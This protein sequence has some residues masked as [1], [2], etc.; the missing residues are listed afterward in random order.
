MKN[1]NVVALV[2]LRGGSKSI[3][4]KNIKLLNGKPL[5]YYVLKAATSAA[6]IDAVYVST[7]SDRIAAIVDSL[8]MDINLIKR[9]AE[10]ATDESST[11][12]VMLHFA[13]SV[14]FETLI[15][16][17]ATSPLTTNEHLN[18]A[19]NMLV[20]EGYD[21]LLTGV[22]TLRFYWGLDGK[23]LNYNPAA[24]PRRQDF[25][26]V[27]VENGAFYITKRSILCQQKCRLGGEIGIYEMPETSEVELDEPSDWSRVST[28]LG[29]RTPAELTKAASSV[30]VLFCDVDG[31][32]TDGGM[33]YSSQGEHLKKFNTRDAKGLS[34][35]RDCSIRV[36]ILTQEDSE[37]VAARMRKLG[38]EEYY[39]GIK[40]KQTF[41][42]DY[43]SRHNLDMSQVAFVGD[44][45]NDLEC[46]SMVGFSAC[47]ADASP[48][49]VE[50]CGFKSQNMGGRGAVREACD[51]I[52]NCHVPKR[53]RSR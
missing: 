10:F 8:E 42:R 51:Y 12:S 3:P 17:Q 53:Y 39:P 13:E 40:D 41:L 11:E 2:P 46:L 32:L 23:P 27:I 45:L 16:L 9:P 26:G 37:V 14:P 5:C 4:H 15:T 48:E 1:D 30:R 7:D 44:D 21:S 31:T 49:V 43:C 38:I 28:M 6:C 33:Y 36:V 22:R 35:L 29:D 52:R 20:S 25:E 18:E 47:P 34:M 24:R 19:Y 50:I